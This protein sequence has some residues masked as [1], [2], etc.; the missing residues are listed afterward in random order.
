MSPGG[1]WK[2][3][4][5]SS[6]GTSYS[7]H[8]SFEEALMAACSFAMVPHQTVLRIEGP[9]GKMYDQAY[10]NAECARRRRQQT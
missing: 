7:T 3:Y 4:L 8:D 5:S 1:E 10:I 2:L 6:A 9:S